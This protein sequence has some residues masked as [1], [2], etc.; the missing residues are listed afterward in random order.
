MDID[1]GDGEG[2]FRYFSHLN[3]IVLIVTNFIISEIMMMIKIYQG[4]I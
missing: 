2:V 4:E 3:N 1:P